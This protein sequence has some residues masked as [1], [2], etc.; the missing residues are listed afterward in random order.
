MKHNNKTYYH[1]INTALKQ[2]K[3]LWVIVLLTAC[4]SQK[5]LK[6][7]LSLTLLPPGTI[8]IGTNLFCD[9]G[10]IGNI[11]WREY[12]YWTSQVYGEDSKTLQYALPDT[13]VWLKLDSCYHIFASEYYRHPAFNFHPVVGVSQKQVEKYTQWRSDRVFEIF[14]V[15]Q[16]M[17]SR[18]TAQSP[19]THFTIN[20]YYQGELGSYLIDTFL[21]YY[22]EFRLPTIQQATDILAYSDS[23]NLYFIKN[24]KSKSCRE[25]LKAYPK[26]TSNIDTCAE[27]GWSYEPTV[28]MYGNY[29][30]IT[31]KSYL[32]NLRGNVP[33]WTSEPG[34]TFGGSWND[35]RDQILKSPIFDNIG[36]NACTGFRNVCTWKKRENL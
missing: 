32:E 1:T 24:C 13:T 3:F 6:S 28:S 16:K 31:S 21:L 12:I 7:Y 26:I 2:L 30:S 15:N 36:A 25:Q 5:N 9:E 14:L 17:I 18:D 33:E 27:S 35:D 4:A 23:T 29:N 8:S 34:K 19:K 22:P 10:E 11:E 20:R